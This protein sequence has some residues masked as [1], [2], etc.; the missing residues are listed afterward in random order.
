MEKNTYLFIGGPY[1][2]KRILVDASL[3]DIKMPSLEDGVVNEVVYHKRPLKTS[4][5]VYFIWAPELMSL[6]EAIPMLLNGYNPQAKREGVFIKPED[7][8][9][10]SIQD[11]HLGKGGSFYTEYEGGIWLFLPIELKPDEILKQLTDKSHWMSTK[12]YPEQPGHSNRTMIRTEEK[13]YFVASVKF[14]NGRI[15]D[16][17]FRE[18]RGE[19]VGN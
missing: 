7:V 11:E 17:Y 5:D 6:D 10:K 14:P 15:W 2:G 9:T 12:Q 8:K 1:D 16:S 4:K 19:N 18:F 3:V 13:D